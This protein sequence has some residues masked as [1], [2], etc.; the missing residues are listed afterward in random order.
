MTIERERAARL[1]EPGRLAAGLFVV[2]VAAAASITVM[3]TTMTLAGLAWVAALLFSAPGDR[4][5]PDRCLALLFG[6]LGAWSLV[7]AAASPEP[8][9]SLGASASVLLWVAAPLAS[10]VLDANAARR[11]RALLLAEAG[12][13]G[14]WAVAEALFWWDKDPLARVRGPFSNHMTLA[15]FLMVATLQALPR[16]DLRPLLPGWSRPSGAG[17]CPGELW[18]ARAATAVGLAGV[19]ATLTRSALLALLCGLAVLAVTTPA[20]RQARQAGA[21]VLVATAVLVILSL[22]L[23]W[24]L[25]DRPGL[26]AS[27]AASMRDRVFLWRAGLAM[28]AERPVLGIGANRVRHE[29]ARFVQSGYRRTGPPSHLHSA[30]LTLAAERGLPALGLVVLIYGQTLWRFRRP[31]ARGD[32]VRRGALAAV[33]GFLVMGLFED[34]FGDSEVLFVHLVTLAALWNP[35]LPG[36]AAPGGPAGP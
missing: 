29:A 10:A 35:H 27:A 12:V 1:L 16:P 34:N 13:L 5:A 7:S 31:A 2:A 3:E 15:G 28:V 32:P 19:A 11:V 6:A 36:P 22:L 8:A 14:V 4:P 17:R 24:M 18:L 25:S 30:P 23:P 21:L 26:A 9:R 33:T 20:R